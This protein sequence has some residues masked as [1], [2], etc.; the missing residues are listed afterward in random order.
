MANSK[1]MSVRR[2][3]KISLTAILLVGTF[4]GCSQNTDRPR[5]VVSGRVTYDDQPVAKGRIRFEPLPGTVGNVSIGVINQGRYKIDDLGGVPVGQHR[6]KIL[7]LDPNDTAGGPGG[8]PQKQFLPAKYNY[9][10]AL[11]ATIEPAPATAIHD[12][13]LEK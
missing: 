10:S 13:L 1:A 2:G 6:V 3:W 5:V 8:P 7:S 11:E 9:Q 4:G 12:F